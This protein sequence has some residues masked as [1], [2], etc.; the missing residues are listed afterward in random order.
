MAEA[1]SAR[2]EDGASPIPPDL[3]RRLDDVRLG[4]LSVHKALLDHER[5]RYERSTGRRVATSGE[6][7]QLALSAPFFAWIQPLAQAIVQLDELL[8]VEGPS[9]T[10][11]RDAEAMIAR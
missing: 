10:V 8:A 7:L 5:V 9:G 11:A 1:E 2:K 3:R 4:L 6:F